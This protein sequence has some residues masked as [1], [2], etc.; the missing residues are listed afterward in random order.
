MHFYWYKPDPNEHR[1]YVKDNV[2]AWL[3][4][5]AA[6]LTISWYLALFVNIVPV[7]INYTI[8]IAWGHVSENVRT[9]TEMYNGVKDTIKP[10]FYAASAWVSWVIIFSGIYDLYDMDNPNSS[11]AEYTNRVSRNYFERNFSTD[12]VQL[13]DVVEFMFFFALVI[14]GQKMLSHAI[15]RSQTLEA[16]QSC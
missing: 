7:V 11:R 12:I 4:W 9:R 3:F 6:N 15:G 1:R 10:V 5:A 8:A 2:E 13:Y 14:C 16:I